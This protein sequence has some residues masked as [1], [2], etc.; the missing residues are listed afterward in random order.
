MNLR[1]L[2][3]SLLI[4]PL[5]SFAQ[6]GNVEVDVKLTPVNSFIAKTGKV[7]GFAFRTTDGIKAENV[8]ID[9]RTI[10]TDVSLRDKHTK[11]R[12]MVDKHPFAKLIS[13]TGKDGKGEAE[14]EIKGI[15]KKYSGTYTIAG[16]T[17]KAEFPIHLP[18]LEIKNIR[19]L[20]V[21]VKDDVLVRVNL[22]IKAAG[23]VK[24]SSAAKE[25]PTPK[26]KPKK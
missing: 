5:A 23:A 1:V 17:L 15:K 4:L 14:I 25:K 10:T 2:S 16:E 26:A 7:E 22:P 9:L 3:L 21:G 18:D 12:L 20:G 6:S 13:A 24:E 11:E 19:Y 8:L